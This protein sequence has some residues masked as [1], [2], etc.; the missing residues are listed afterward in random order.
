MKV[1]GQN[2]YYTR[3]SLKKLF[4]KYAILFTPSIILINLLKFSSF[5][6]GQAIQAYPL[7]ICGI[8]DSMLPWAPSKFTSNI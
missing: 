4:D 5:K 6:I 2:I 8:Q 3:H 1:L 7:Q